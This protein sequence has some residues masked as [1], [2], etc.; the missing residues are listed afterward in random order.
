MARIARQPVCGESIFGYQLNDCAAN[1]CPYILCIYIRRIGILA[2]HCYHAIIYFLI[3]S[4]L[5]K[6]FGKYRIKN[7]FELKL[8][9][10]IFIPICDVILLQTIL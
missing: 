6:L 5:F 9:I 4:T 8:I 7:I 10:L 1:K 2:E 3:F